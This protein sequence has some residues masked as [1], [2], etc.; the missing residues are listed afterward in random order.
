MQ[1]VWSPRARSDLLNIGRYIEAD[2]PVAA[3]RVFLRIIASVENL[4]VTPQMGTPDPVT[5]TRKLFIPGLPYFVHY[6]VK[7]DAVQILR[8]YHTAR[9]WPVEFD[10]WALIIVS[11]THSP[12]CPL[13]RA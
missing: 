2:N 3:R 4:P 7:E 5:N 13:S 9:K 1:I 6:R 10:L 12:G 11:S 8:V